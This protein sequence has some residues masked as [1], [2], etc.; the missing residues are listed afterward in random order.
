MD[1]N[2]GVLALIKEFSLNTKNSEA[3]FKNNFWWSKQSLSK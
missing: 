2:R 3:K 1:N